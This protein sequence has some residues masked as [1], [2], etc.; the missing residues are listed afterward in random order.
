MSLEMHY[1]L[2]PP[3]P[4]LLPTDKGNR[5]PQRQHFYMDVYD[6][7]FSPLE[8]DP[9]Q[10]LEIGIE[11]GTS[12]HLWSTFFRN[13][14]ISG[15]DINIP[16]RADMLLALG[17]VN[18]FLR[19]AYDIFT[20]LDLCRK[21]PP[22]DIIIDDADHNIGNQMWALERYSSLVKPGGYYICEDLIVDSIPHMMASRK[23]LGRRTTMEIHDQTERDN[24][25]GDGY[26]VL[27]VLKF[28]D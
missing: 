28:I 15:M 11:T 10:L 14:T 5:N 13:G 4:G 19:N 18:L 20:V 23:K 7:L 8:H 16:E 24:G 22:Q 12:V 21:I 27:M 9:V 3:L 6:R 2:L 26:D 17:N 25:T 1:G